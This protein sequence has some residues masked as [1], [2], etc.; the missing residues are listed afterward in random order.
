[1]GCEQEGE[2]YEQEGHL[3]PSGQEG[4]RR[5][6]DQGLR[7]DQEG[8]TLLQQGEGVQGL[9]SG[10]EHGEAPAPAVGI[11]TAVERRSLQFSSTLTNSGGTSCWSAWTKDVI[12]G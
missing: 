9:N 7:C 3:D 5:F 4:A 8:L 11:S 10:D 12:I 2:R 1:M 6:E